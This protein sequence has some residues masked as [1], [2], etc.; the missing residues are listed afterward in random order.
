[1]G[2]A[3][4]DA[5]LRR[6]TSY[7]CIVAC[8]TRG[9]GNGRAKLDSRRAIRPEAQSGALKVQSLTLSKADSPK[10]KVWTSHQGQAPL[11][12]LSLNRRYF[13]SSS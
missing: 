3:R 11:R 8:S 6:I 7:T 12:P 10:P 13:L 5:L 9:G 1:M 4:T 2:R